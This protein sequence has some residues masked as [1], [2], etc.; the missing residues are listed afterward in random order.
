[1]ILSAVNVYH[2]FHFYFIHKDNF[3][4]T[5]YLKDTL[6]DQLPGMQDP[7]LLLS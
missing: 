4:H 6:F 5:H 7:K 1:M 3:I 2:T